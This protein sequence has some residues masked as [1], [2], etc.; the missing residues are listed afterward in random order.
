MAEFMN[1]NDVNDSRLSFLTRSLGVDPALNLQ[2]D[3]GGS[4]SSCFMSCGSAGSWPAS[5]AD[6]DYI[7]CST[8]DSGF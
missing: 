3:S 5:D 1:Q 8:D 2:S 7:S 6:D 4:C